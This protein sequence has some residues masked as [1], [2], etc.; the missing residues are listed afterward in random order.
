MVVVCYIE[1]PEEVQIQELNN[2]LEK[3]KVIPHVEKTHRDNLLN[4]NLYI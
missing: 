3:F 4:S 2:L 1:H